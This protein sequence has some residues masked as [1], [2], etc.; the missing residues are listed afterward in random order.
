MKKYLLYLSIPIMMWSCANE[1]LVVDNSLK[2]DKQQKG[3]CFS[4][5]IK[6]ITK[7]APAKLQDFKRYNFGVFGYKST[8]PTY[9]VIE[10]YLV[11]YND[12][13]NKCGYYMTTDSQTT[14]GD[15]TETVDGQSYWSYE[16]LGYADYTYA[17]EDGYIKAS[18]TSLMSN[19]ANQ[20]L[21][22]WDEAA[23][24]TTFYAYSPYIN[25][26]GTAT[27]DNG[28]KVLT[29]PSQSLKDG[30]DQPQ[31]YEYM[32][33][34]KTVAKDDYGKDVQLSFKRLNAKVNIKFYE[35]IEGYSIQIIDLKAGKYNG[36]QATPAKFSVTTSGYSAGEYY[37]AI[38]YQLD[39]SSS[40]TAPTITQTY[41][42]TV[43]NTRPLIFKAPVETAIGETKSAASASPTTYY[44]L[45][46]NNDTGFTFHVSYELTSTTGEKIVVKNATVLV[47]SD[48]CNWKAN[49][50]YTYIFKITKDTNGST[51]PDDDTTIDPT[52]PSVGTEQA[53]FPIVFDGANVEDWTPEE[54]EHVI[55]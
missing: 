3:M 20:Y 51:D 33:A 52:D 14:L 10:N 53:L 28:T 27:F 19:Y 26:S 38:G 8:D 48:K 25:G 22:Y 4:S 47:P 46:K 54:S 24:T 7:A 44:A 40:E 1:D 9:P 55:S 36:V 41:G 16:K 39:F 6:N 5:S 34:A 2:A 29:I 45:P 11:G 15:K 43:T 37:S 18:E 35:V 17:G 23:P 50:A 21:R 12:D 30:Y 32:W 13:A 42:T 31:L 49:T